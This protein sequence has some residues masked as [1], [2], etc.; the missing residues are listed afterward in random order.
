MKEEVFSR[1]QDSAHLQQF[2]TVK[3]MGDRA[4]CYARK[5]WC[6]IACSKYSRVSGLSIVDPGDSGTIKSF[7]CLVTFLYLYVEYGQSFAELIKFWCMDMLCY[8]PC[9]FESQMYF[10]IVQKKKEEKKYRRTVFA[11]P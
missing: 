8:L 6:S 4:L 10:L 11:L 1:L 2:H 5:S 9:Y 3:K 7:G